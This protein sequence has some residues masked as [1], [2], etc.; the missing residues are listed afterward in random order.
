MKKSFLLLSS[1]LILLALSIFAGAAE[2]KAGA[3]NT[4]TELHDITIFFANDVR[5]ETEPCG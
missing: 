3:I 4:P 1:L 2:K 5:G